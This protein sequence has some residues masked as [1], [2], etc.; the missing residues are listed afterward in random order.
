MCFALGVFVYPV[1]YLLFSSRRRH[2]RCA[3]VTGVQTCALPISALPEAGDRT[4]DQPREIGAQ[5]RGIEPIFDEPADLVILD[6]DIGIGEQRAHLGLPFGRRDVY[7]DAPLAAVA[8]MIIGRTQI[9]AAGAGNER[10]PP[11]ARVVARARPLDLDA[12]STP[13]R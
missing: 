9:L 10:R 11:F 5:P 2:T 6:H 12:L 3:L 4:D 7:R 1:L 8:A 13:L